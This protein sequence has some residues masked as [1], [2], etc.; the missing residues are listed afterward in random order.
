MTTNEEFFQTLEKLQKCIATESWE[1][2]RRQI[3]SAIQLCPA[4]FLLPYLTQYRKMIMS[5]QPG[6]VRGKLV[7]LLGGTWA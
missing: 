3:N 5:K 7:Q 1:A 4:P 6:P 2:A